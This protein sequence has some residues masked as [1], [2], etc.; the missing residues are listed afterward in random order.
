MIERLNVLRKG[1]RT[2]LGLSKIK[3]PTESE[4][5]IND[6]FF[7]FFRKTLCLWLRSLRSLRSHFLSSLYE[8]YS[9]RD[10]SDRSGEQPAPDPPSEGFSSSCCLHL[11]PASLRSH[12]SR[13]GSSADEPSRCCDPRGEEPLGS[14]RRGRGSSGAPARARR[15]VSALCSSSDDLKGRNRLTCTSMSRRALRSVSFQPSKRKLKQQSE[16]SK[17]KVPHNVRQRYVNMFTEEFL[18]STHDVNE[19]FQKVSRRRLQSAALTST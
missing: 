4:N 7:F 15:C 12:S 5:D 8:L 10:G 13:S 16:A 1:E 9:R 17:E 11:H 14:A 18:K 2:D 19:A 6:C 3:L